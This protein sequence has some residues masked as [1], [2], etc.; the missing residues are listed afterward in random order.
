[1]CR[2]LCQANPH[3][4]IFWH[5]DTCSGDDTWEKDHSLKDILLEKFPEQGRQLCD[6]LERDGRV[7]FTEAYMLQVNEARVVAIYNEL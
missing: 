5:R 1:V 3:L 6:E 7:Q 2:L 4:L